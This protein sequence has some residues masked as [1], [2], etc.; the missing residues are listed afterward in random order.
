MLPIVRTRKVLKKNPAL[1]PQG[2]YDFVW[3]GSMNKVYNIATNV[4]KNKAKAT[5]SVI[6]FTPEVSVC[7][8]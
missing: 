1:M 6:E 2:K 8:R 4:V 7:V 5:Q 3:L